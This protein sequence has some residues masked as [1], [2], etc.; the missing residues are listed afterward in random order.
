[1]KCF[2]HPNNMYMIGYRCSEVI[3]FQRSPQAG[4][5]EQDQIQSL[6]IKNVLYNN[7]FIPVWSQGDLTDI[8]LKSELR[9]LNLLITMQRLPGWI[10]AVLPICKKCLLPLSLC[11]ILLIR[12]YRRTEI[13]AIQ[14]VSSRG[15]FGLVQIDMNL[16]QDRHDYQ[17]KYYKEHP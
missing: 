8:Y 10:L 9:L 17:K 16:S 15:A 4:H 5:V 3:F 14:P 7:M 1:M 12:E 2:G 11:W 13:W 6:Q